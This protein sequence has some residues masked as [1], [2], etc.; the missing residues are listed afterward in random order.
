M[1]ANYWGSS[2]AAIRLI[3]RARSRGVD[4]WADQYPYNSTGGD[5]AT[6]LIPAWVLGDDAF[7]S[8]RGGQKTKSDYGAALRRAMEDGGKAEQ[9]RTGIQ[10]E[11]DR[12]GGSEN[13]VIFDHPDRS[14]VGKSLDALASARGV[15]PVQMALQ[16]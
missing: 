8:A 2:N 7:S 16:L 4:V 13:I 15:T 12:R 1:G 3:M 9:V 14:F 6:V 11:I 5:G 10:H